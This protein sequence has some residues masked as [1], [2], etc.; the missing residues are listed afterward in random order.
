MRA[1][2]KD[3]RDFIKEAGRIVYDASVHGDCAVIQ[4]KVSRSKSASSQPPEPKRIPVPPTI[5]HFVM[6]LPD[7]AITFLHRFRGTY[8]G[9]EHLFEPHTDVKLPM[10]H[11]HCFAVKS[12]DEV[13]LNDICQRIFDQ[14]GVRFTPGDS[15]N[16]GEVYIH[17]VRDVA[18]KKRMFCASFRLP[19]EVAFSETT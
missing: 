5:S 15:Q 1:F 4:P 9:L 13:P 11:V 3:G 6:N 7:S 10:V 16:E 19:P 2:N 14:I 8:R 12:D 18:P 17:N